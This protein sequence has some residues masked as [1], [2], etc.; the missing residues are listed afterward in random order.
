MTRLFEIVFT[1]LGVAFVLWAVPAF[2]KYLD[3]Y[4][5]K[6][7]KNKKENNDDEKNKKVYT[8]INT[9]PPKREEERPIEVKIK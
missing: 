2:S 3:K 9:L 4:V 1:L 6:M 5:P 8:G 7:K